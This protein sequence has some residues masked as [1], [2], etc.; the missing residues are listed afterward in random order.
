MIL[1][2]VKQERVVFLSSTF[3]KYIHDM[4]LT[5]KKQQRKNL[6]QQQLP[7]TLKRMYL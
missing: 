2:R 1:N 3:L 5:K 6:Q 7:G 4:Q